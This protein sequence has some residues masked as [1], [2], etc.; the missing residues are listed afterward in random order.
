MWC[1]WSCVCMCAHV[2]MCSDTSYRV[3]MCFHCA[4]VLCVHMCCLWQVCSLWLRGETVGQTDI[5]YPVRNGG[6][7]EKLDPSIWLTKVPKELE[8]SQ[9]SHAGR[10]RWLKPVPAALETTSLERQRWPGSATPWWL[11]HVCFCLLFK[12]KLH[13]MT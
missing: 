3:H 6:L 4:C 2:Y 11:C 8:F 7:K 1:V 12:P 10:R 9:G 13:I 5:H